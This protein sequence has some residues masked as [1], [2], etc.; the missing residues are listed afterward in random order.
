MIALYFYSPVSHSIDW[1]IYYNSCMGFA[2]NFIYLVALGSNEQGDHP[3]RDK[4]DYGKILSSDFFKC[5][6]N[7]S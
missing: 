6:I 3:F 2:H 5:H 1:L 7:I 4:Y